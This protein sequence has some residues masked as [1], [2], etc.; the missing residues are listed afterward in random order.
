MT[1]DIFKSKFKNFTKELKNYTTV[2]D[3]NDWNIKGFIDINKNIFTISTDTKLV[4]K[5]LELHI[6]PKIAKFAEDNNFKLILPSSQNYYPDLTFEL[7]TDSKIK[8][9]VDIKT[10]F[11]RKKGKNYCEFTLGSHGTYFEH[12]DL[13]KNIQFPYNQYKG[14]FVLG[15]VYNQQSNIDETKSYEIK[16]LNKITSVINNLKFFFIEKWKIASDKQGSGNTANIGGLLKVE[17]DMENGNGIFKNEKEFDDFWINYNKISI[18]DKNGKS[19]KITKI[20]ELREYRGLNKIIVPPIKCQGIKTKLVADIKKQIPKNFDGIWIEPFMGSG[21]VGFNIQ[22]KNAIFADT[23]PHIINFYNDIKTGQINEYIAKDF[24]IYE[25][26]KLQKYSDVYYKEV[27]NRF[28]TT[29]NSLDFLFLNRSCFNGMIR[30]N[31]KGSFNVPFCKKPNRFN[32]SY[33]TKITN[34]IKNIRLVIQ[35]NNYNF[36]CDSFENVINKATN[37]DLIYC[38]PPY[39]DRYCDYY[40]AWSETDEKKLFNN[41]D[42]KSCNFILSSWHHNKYRNNK[43]IESLWGKFN[44]NFIEHKYFVGGKKETMNDMTEVLITNFN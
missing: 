44:L 4:S 40:N 7:K 28:N 19:K 32:K 23:N 41:L 36:I 33:I 39:I 38:D 27:R 1:P 31:Q 26:Q 18:I 2:G 37:N 35:I 16:D 6:F 9:A 21:V 30:F 25:S 3:N 15:I 20:S 14:H 24:L 17:S 5:I 34:Q 42:N 22:P 11:K 8:Y 12:R 43:Y 29:P 13:A 10:T